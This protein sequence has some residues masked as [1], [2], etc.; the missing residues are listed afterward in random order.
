MNRADRRCELWLYFFTHCDSAFLTFASNS[1]KIC[2]MLTLGQRVYLP[3]KRL[4][5]IGG[6]LFGIIVLSPLLLFALIAGAISFHGHPI[7]KSIRLGKNEKP[8]AFYKFRSMK[9]GAPMK[10]AEDFTDEE[11][12]K[13]TTKWGTF[14]RKT[15]ID[16]ML[17]L[18]SILKGDMSFIGPRPMLSAE[19]EPELYAARKSFK[20][21][22]FEMRPG[23][24]GYAQIVMKRDPDVMEKAKND[25]YY[26][27][28]FSMWMDI[29]LFVLSFM[30]LFGYNAGK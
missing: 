20:P 12:K 27:K 29:K 23:L 21:T 10:G 22:A 13:Y 3:I 4:V 14:I 1:K 11:K 24:S 9:I 18:F 16:E 15:S 26:V 7:F 2:R 19:L 8:F 5:D 30:V 28:N 17:Q 6:S 25:S